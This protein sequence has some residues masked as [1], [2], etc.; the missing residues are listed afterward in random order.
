MSKIA[1]VGVGAWG[2][3]LARN[4]MELGCLAAVCSEHFSADQLEQWQGVP[5]RNFKELLQ[6]KS[7]K[8]IVIAT[9]TPSHKHLTEE[10]LKAGKH[11]FV[12]KPLANSSEEAYELCDVAK[13]HEKCL[14]VGHL[15]RYHP[16]FERL[17]SEVQSGAIGDVLHISLRRC[18]FGK[19]R[20][21]E[22]I[23]RDFAPHDLSM[24]YALLGSDLEFNCKTRATGPKLMPNE[25]QVS[26][27]LDVRE[28]TVDL[29]FSRV[30]PIK[31]QMIIV[32]GSKGILIFDDTKPWEEKLSMGTYQMPTKSIGQEPTLKI[33]GL[34]VQKGEPLKIE[35]QHFLRC[36]ES[37]SSCKTPGEEG[38]LVLKWMETIGV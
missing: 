6:D 14:M 3:N 38:A 34:S 20:S 4:F 8:G 32:Q 11:V 25:D 15:M 16:C 2:K 37:N 7:I 13:R 36:V 28:K 33:E 5:V 29:F 17:L 21:Y 31:E 23:V 10:A 24:L 27:S 30:W 1:I 12:E 19:F 26:V 9:P 22:S 18:N 35:C